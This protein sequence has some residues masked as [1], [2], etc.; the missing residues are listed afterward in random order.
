M[1]GIP[2]EFIKWFFA[3]GDLE[4]DRNVFVIS[5]LKFGGN[6]DFRVIEKK[7]D[8]IFIFPFYRE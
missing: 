1:F 5:I 2:D 8:R 6:F 7:E 4:C 3:L